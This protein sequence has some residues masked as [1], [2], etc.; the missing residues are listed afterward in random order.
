[1][2]RAVLAAAAGAVLP[3]L[4]R[5]GEAQQ[6]SVVEGEA[7]AVDGDTLIVDGHRIRIHALYAP[8]ASEPGG[9]AAKDM[10]A[11]VV[12]GEYVVCTVAGADSFG[13]IVADCIMS[14]DG[15]DFAE[16]M[17]RAGHADH[18]PA[19][20]PARSCLP[21]GQRFQAARLLSVASADPRPLDA[22]M[23]RTGGELRSPHPELSVCSG[24][25]APLS[26]TDGRR[27]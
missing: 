22:T 18:C 23:P 12:Y 20:W 15:A 19:Q 10:A 11:L 21:S 13:R 24:G 27:R 17:I 7:T 6:P 1:M 14:S 26:H 9:A 16:V 8:E 25:A 2:C 5:A 4:P 3:S